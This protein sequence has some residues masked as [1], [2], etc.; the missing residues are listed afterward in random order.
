M[1]RT[2]IAR[3]MHPVA[4][5]QVTDTTCTTVTPVRGATNWALVGVIGAVALSWACITLAAL[6]KGSSTQ[7]VD[8][9]VS[10]S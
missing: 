9:K 1:F 3:V 6:S 8:R 5:D 4:Q 2:L 7:T 10:H